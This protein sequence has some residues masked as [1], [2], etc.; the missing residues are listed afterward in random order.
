M[1]VLECP[2]TE[3]S[4]CV[5]KDREG[6]WTIHGKLIPLRTSMKTS[7]TKEQQQKP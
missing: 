2:N 1:N 4:Y 7:K 3:D 5:K 6:I